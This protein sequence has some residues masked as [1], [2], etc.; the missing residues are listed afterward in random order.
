VFRFTRGLDQLGDKPQRCLPQ[1]LRRPWVVP[2]V[3]GIVK[4]ATGGDALGLVLM[5]PVALA[6]LLVLGS[7]GGRQRAGARPAVPT[8]AG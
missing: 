6:C 5:A 4:S 8:A 7:L 1:R 2:L 3:M